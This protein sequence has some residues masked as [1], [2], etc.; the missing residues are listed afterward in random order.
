[1]QLIRK[2]ITLYD[3]L[4]H[5]TLYSNLETNSSLEQE[6]CLTVTEFN[7]PKKINPNPNKNK[8]NYEYIYIPIEIKQ[9]VNLIGIYNDFTYIEGN[10]KL[11]EVDFILRL[12]EVNLESYLTTDTNKIRGYCSSKINTLDTYGNLII[13]TNYDPDI[14]TFSGVLLK[15]AEKIVYVI[16]GENNNGYVP[17]TGIKY[18]DYYNKVQL[19]FNNGSYK[20]IPLTEFEFFNKGYDINNTSLFDIVKDD[21][22]IEIIEIKKT[23][24]EI[25]I[26]RGTISVFNN[27][28][29][30]S[31]INTFEDLQQYK[32]NIFDL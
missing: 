11:D 7:I 22:L 10:S 2:K 14:N 29:S 1:M 15:T 17:N 21:T 5:K 30:L 25:E 26:D 19:I 31:E 13:G 12:S 3:L 18:T 20:E 32:N 24:N 16:G 4:D 23:E 28:F 27:F 6:E 9:T 8:I